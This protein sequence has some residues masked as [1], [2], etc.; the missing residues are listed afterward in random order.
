MNRQI[1][2]RRLPSGRV[3][4]FFKNYKTLH[5]GRRF[6]LRRTAL[7]TC[8]NALQYRWLRQNRQ[9]ACKIRH[10]FTNRDSLIMF[11]LIHGTPLEWTR[12]QIHQ[13]ARRFLCSTKKEFATNVPEKNFSYRVYNGLIIRCNVQDNAWVGRESRQRHPSYLP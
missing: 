11:G 8:N 6:F 5:T 3:C 2:R 4:H 1:T 10:R 9:M 12:V 13:N 7:G